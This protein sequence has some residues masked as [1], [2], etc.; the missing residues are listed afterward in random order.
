MYHG[1]YDAAQVL[2]HPDYEDHKGRAL[3]LHVRV[4]S[5]A[6]KYFVEPLQPYANALAIEL[7]K[8]WGAVSPIFVEAVHEIYTG[9]QNLSAGTSLREGALVAAMDNALALF[10]SSNENVD[11]TGDI[12][13]EETPDFMKDW[14]RAMSLCNHTLTNA[15]TNLEAVNSVLNADNCKLSEKYDKLKVYATELKACYD[16]LATKNANLTMVHNDLVNRQMPD[17]PKHGSGLAP[18]LYLCPNCQVMFFKVMKGGLYHHPCFNGGWCGK[19]DKGGLVLNYEG[20]QKHLV[21]KT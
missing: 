18:D 3:L 1:D 16:E 12:L 14:N 17:K 5:L 15:N 7:L 19:L 11:G 20:W 13:F 9:T 2:P 8:S 6:Q 21:R 10:G 4:V